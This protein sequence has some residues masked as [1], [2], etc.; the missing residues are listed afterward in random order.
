VCN[1]EGCPFVIFFLLSML[2]GNCNAKY[3]DT[4]MAA[5]YNYD[6][7]ISDSFHNLC[8]V[9]LHNILLCRSCDCP[10]LHKFPDFLRQYKKRHDRAVH[11]G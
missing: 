9:A 1:G 5:S 8:V 11:T 7:Y 4:D 10:I 2:V 6:F 3:S